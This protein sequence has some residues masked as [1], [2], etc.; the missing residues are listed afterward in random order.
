MESIIIALLSASSVKA[1]TTHSII[2]FVDADGAVRRGA[3]VGGNR[4]RLLHNSD[5]DGATPLSGT[6][7]WLLS[8]RVVAVKRLLAPI[9][10]PPAIYAIGLNYW[11][12]IN[13]SGLTPPQTPSL[14]YKNL[15]AFTDPFSPIE[16]PILKAPNGTTYPTRPDYEGELG[17]IIGPAGCKDV[18]FDDAMSCVQGFTICH[19]VSMRCF[20]S[21]ENGTCP[22]N[23]GQFSFSKG[24]DTHAPTGPALVSAAQLGDGS[25]LVL[26]TKVNG[27]LRQNVSTSE[28]IFGV[29]SIISFISQGTTLVG[30]ALLC[31]GTPDGVGDTMRPQSYLV[32]GDVIDIEIGPIG[33]LSN[34]VAVKGG[35]Q[36]WRAPEDHDLDAFLPKHPSTA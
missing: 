26:S 18:S 33:K 17:L 15:H 2:R 6:G 20:Q 9:P 28:L 34:R 3:Y 30:G 25:G 23:G 35:P 29:K 12:H 22:G 14:F 21:T 1:S 32:D 31:T 11:G 27:E 24:L 7:P 10:Q 5:S 19:D 16:V 4:A 36:R 8:D 13:A